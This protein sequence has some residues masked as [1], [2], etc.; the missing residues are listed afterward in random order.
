MNAINKESL[1]TCTF[2]FQWVWAYQQLYMS[3]SWNYFFWLGPGILPYVKFTYFNIVSQDPS[4]S[5]PKIGDIT[6][7]RLLRVRDSQ[8]PPIFPH[9]FDPLLF[10]NHYLNYLDPIPPAIVKDD[11][12]IA[13]FLFQ[14]EEIDI[15][16]MKGGITTTITITTVTRPTNHAK[17]SIFTWH[18]Y[19]TSWHQNL[20]PSYESSPWNPY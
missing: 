17:I 10:P 7:S 14:V 4:G 18:Q 6:L 11:L 15:V 12:N 2:P 16:G 3:K 8:N 20:S 9:Q 5:F 13:Y 1:R 19:S